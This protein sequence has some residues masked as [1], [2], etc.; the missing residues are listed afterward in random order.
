MTIKPSIFVT[1]ATGGMGR[2]TA[3]LFAQRGWKVGLYD[4][5]AEALAAFAA[6]LPS[7]QVCYQVLDVRSEDQ[8]AMAAKQFADFSEERCDVLFNNAGIAPGGAF[9]SMPSEQI[10]DVVDINVHGVM[11]GIR[12]LLPLLK[13]TSNSICISTS[14]SVATFGHAGR[15]V[16]SASKAAVKGL[17]EALSLEF[18]Q[19]GVRTADILPG[20]IDTP[21]LRNALAAGAGRPF[22][23]SM[24]N[25]LPDS[26][27][28]RRISVQ[29][30]ADAVWQAYQTNDALHWYVPEEV[31]AIDAM[32]STAARAATR[33]F[34]FR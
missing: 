8:F 9:E 21:M 4:L 17:T 26:G 2:A 22:E 34:L 3:A 18:E 5:N 20:C 6:K 1:G 33:E 25:S 12:A 16:Y 19:Y 23:A 29:A 30:I 11:N 24:L 28:Y 32:D 13:R 10:R 31:G 15:A 7:T 27:P 14:S